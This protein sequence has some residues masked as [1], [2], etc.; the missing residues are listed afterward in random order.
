MTTNVIAC[1]YQ[2]RIR[3][4]A[5][6]WLNEI[7]SP[8]GLESYLIELAPHPSTPSYRVWVAEVAIALLSFEPNQP[9]PPYAPNADGQMTL[10]F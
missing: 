2:S 8:D 7:K 5:S 3:R 10:L 4:L 6:E 1:R 9:A